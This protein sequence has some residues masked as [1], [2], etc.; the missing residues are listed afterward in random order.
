MPA[1]LEAQVPNLLIDA[2][3]LSDFVGRSPMGCCA[4]RFFWHK[5]LPQQVVICYL[6]VSCWLHHSIGPKPVRITTA[7][8]RLRL[9]SVFNSGLLKIQSASRCPPA[10]S[11]R[12]AILS[13]NQNDDSRKWTAKSYSNTKAPDS[14]IQ[15]R[16]IHVISQAMI[17]AFWD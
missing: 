16:D 10:F 11:R 8:V 7:S 4:S 3:A 13:K 9:F 12:A 1:F 5:R 17:W 6:R 2:C 14:R 15:D